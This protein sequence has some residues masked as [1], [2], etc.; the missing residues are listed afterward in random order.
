MITAGIDLLWHQRKGGRAAGRRLVDLV[1]PLCNLFQPPS[2]LLTPSLSLLFAR[3]FLLYDRHEQQ[4][5]IYRGI[6]YG[7]RASAG[8]IVV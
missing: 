7:G 4:E 6:N 5:S 2:Q 1:T 8:K 3:P